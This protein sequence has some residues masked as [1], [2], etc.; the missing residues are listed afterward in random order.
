M[1]MPAFGAYSESWQYKL[2]IQQ[3]Q[4]VIHSPEPNRDDS[5]TSQTFVQPPIVSAII[6]ISVAP[7][8]EGQLEVPNAG[9]P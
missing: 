4:A 1:F 3:T 8:V 7:S 5:L 9:R 6:Q 2:L